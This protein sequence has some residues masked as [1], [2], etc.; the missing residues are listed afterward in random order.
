VVRELELPDRTHTLLHPLLSDIAARAFYRRDF[1]KVPI[2]LGGRAAEIGTRHSLARQLLES[3]PDAETRLEFMRAICDLN[4]YTHCATVFAHWLHE[5]R[6]HPKLVESLARARASARLADALRSEFVEELASFYGKDA[7][8]QSP[9][10]FDSAS[11]LSE[12]YARHYHHAVPFDPASLSGA[13]QRCAETD[14][15]CRA[16]LDEMRAQN[17]RRE[18]F[19]SR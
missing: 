18:R 15:R 14:A 19:T 4:P 5:D 11:E 13:W 7:G 3:D 17:L 2:G 1:A 9:A 16:R 6:D 10:S 8:A 12:L